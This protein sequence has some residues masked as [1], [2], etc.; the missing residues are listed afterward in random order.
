[1]KF[2]IIYRCDQEDYYCEDSNTVYSEMWEDLVKEIERI[3]QRNT[4]IE[5]KRDLDFNE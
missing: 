4:V 1:M 2:E 3:E 5:I